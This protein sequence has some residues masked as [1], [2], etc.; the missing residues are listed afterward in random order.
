MANQLPYASNGVELSLA[1]LLEYKNHTQKWLPPKKSLWS[2]LNGSHFSAQLGRGMN[3]SEVRQYQ[4]GDD[5]RSIDW[6][7]TA[8]TGKTHTKLFTEEREQPVFLY[9]DL[10]SSMRFGS[11]L[12]L[13]SVQTAHLAALIAWITTDSQD[14]IGALIDTGHHQIELKPTARAK[15]TLYL[16]EQLVQTH[17]QALLDDQQSQP[18][19]RSLS[20]LQRLCPKG[21]DI[22]LVSDFQRLETHHQ[23]IIRQLNQHN[24]MR[25][26]QLFDPLEKGHTQF[27]GQAQVTDGRSSQWFSFGNKKSK[28][29]FDQHWNQSTHAIRQITRELGIP[30]H[31]VSSGQPL[32]DQ[33]AELHKQEIYRG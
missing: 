33:L 19:D 1:E 10:S 26:V 31:L 4:A 30:L 2:Q 21:S 17:N 25:A 20:T 32:L 11:T 27:K 16:L 22:I 18:F 7:V 28:Q 15:G 23:P 8:R 6:R 24:R 5:V 3:F 29:L 12:L 13:K 9:L 14:R